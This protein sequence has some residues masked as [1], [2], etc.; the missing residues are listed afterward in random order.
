MTGAHSPTNPIGPATVTAAAAEQHGEQHRD[1]PGAADVEAEHGAVS[2]PR[3]EHVQAARP[4]H[5]DERRRA[6]PPA[7][8]GRPWRVPDCTSEPLPHANSPMRLL[9]EQEQ[10]QDGQRVEG[11]R[12]SPTPRAP[13]GSGPP[14]RRGRGRAP[15]PAA[16]RPPTNAT[17]RTRERQREP[18]RRHGTTA[19]YAPALTARVSGEAS[20]LR[21]T[22]CSARRPRRARC[23]RAAP[24]ARRGSA[25]RDEHRERLV[26][27]RAGRAAASRSP[28]PTADVP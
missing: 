6:G 1:D 22:D 21:A 11:E 17:R 27:R 15:A 28:T 3:R 26:V 8:P 2:S 18:E 5:E 4:E 14:R 25:R 12:R 10:Q 20:G 19:K 16:A 13:A 7:R 9:L 24:R 23:R